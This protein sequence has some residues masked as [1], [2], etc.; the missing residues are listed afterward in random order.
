MSQTYIPAD[1]RKLVRERANERCEYCLIPENAAFA[2]HEID[3]VIAEKHGGKTDESNLALS[4]D[5]RNGR[6][7]SDISSIDPENGQLTR[8]YNPRQDSWSDHSC[9]VDGK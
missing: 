4:C 3:H 2:L 6:K 9:L 5:L 7:G 1:L 8:L